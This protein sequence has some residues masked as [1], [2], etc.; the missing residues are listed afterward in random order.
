MVVICKVIECPYRSKNG[1]CR[2]RLLNIIENGSCGHI[3]NRNGQPKV[4]WQQK[5]DEKFMQGYKN[6]EEEKKIAEIG[7]KNIDLE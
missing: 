7:M 6:Q 2:N 5:I 3:F 4:N 1:F